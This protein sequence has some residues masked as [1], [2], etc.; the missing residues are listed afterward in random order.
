M[1]LNKKTAAYC[2]NNAA[3]LGLLI[4]YLSRF[5]LL[6]SASKPMSEIYLLQ[7][8][9]MKRI[10]SCVWAER[11]VLGGVKTALKFKSQI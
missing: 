3:Q 4:R 2:K 10:L 9:R 1:L 11:V 8:I 7:T 6:L 5:S